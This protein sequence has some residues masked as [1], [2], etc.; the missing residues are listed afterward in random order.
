MGIF[1]HFEVALYDAD[2]PAALHTN[3]AALAASTD[4]VATR[5]TD[6]LIIFGSGKAEHDS[7]VH[8]E[9]LARGREQYL[10]HQQQRSSC[11]EIRW[12]ATRRS[13]DQPSRQQRM[14]LPRIPDKLSGKPLHPSCRNH[15][16]RPA[17]FKDAVSSF[18]S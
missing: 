6:D 1:T 9:R 3:A 17:E 5:G 11:G 16:H 15:C 13:E 14:A 10:L 7:D 4:S 2:P 12:L 8:I 18:E